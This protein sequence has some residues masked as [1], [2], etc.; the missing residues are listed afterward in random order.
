MNT[1]L[2]LFS[3]S[4]FV[5]ASL[6]S[7][8][9]GQRQQPS[10]EIAGRDTTCQ[11]FLYSPGPT[12]G[13][14]VAYFTDRNQWQDIGQL[15]GSDYGAWGSE[16]KMYSPYVIQAQ[17]GTWR[18]LFSVNNYSPCFAAAYSE[19]LVTWRPQDYPRVKEKG[20]LEPIM[21]Q[22]DPDN[23]DIYFKA[24]D[25]SRHYVQAS[26]DFRH[27]TE[28]A[29]A[30]TIEDAAWMRDTATIAG[31]TFQG[32][33]FDVPKLQLDYLFQY[34]DAMANDARMSAETM[35]DDAKRFASLTSP[36]TTTLTI[37]PS[38]QKTI[39]DRLMGVFFEDI[40]YAADGGL[41]AELVQN[42]DFEYTSDDHRGWDATTAWKSNH[43]IRVSTVE[44]LSK[45]NPHYVLLAK[46][47]TL[48]NT[49]WGR[50]MAEP[51]QQFDFS[52][53][54]VATMDARTSCW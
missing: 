25:G 7:A 34:F 19:D 46:Q 41:Y 12:K 52:V 24:K 17:D 50:V 28:S 43:P 18:L 39:S 10:Y 1:K 42:R 33:A 32:N 13:L 3:T 22:M 37:D 49:G 54:P 16:K 30:S 51:L 44:P 2:L 23:I 40:S 47:D 15:C 26:N 35:K 38:K 14:H 53:L 36:L 8:V 6:P 4:L 20:V 45:N 31:T 11:L 9:W 29:D 48:Y 5:T 27:F 21:F